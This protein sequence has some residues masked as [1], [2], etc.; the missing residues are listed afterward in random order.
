[1]FNAKIRAR[2]ALAGIFLLSTLSC[3]SGKPDVRKADFVWPDLSKP[4]PR[5]GGGEQDAALIVAIGDYAEHND[6]PGAEMNGQEW[7][8]FF[9]ETLG[10]P[11]NRVDVL[12]N[13]AARSDA[14][15]RKLQALAR[16]VSSGGRMWFVF[17]GH[18][19]RAESRTDDGR[20]DGLLVGWEAGVTVNALEKGSLRHSKVQRIL[21]GGPGTPVMVLDTCYSGKAGANETLIEGRAAGEVPEP[22]AESGMVFAAASGSQYAGQLPGARRPAF[23]YLLLG[24]LRGWGDANKDGRVSAA[25]AVGFTKM[26]LMK[27]LAGERDQ[28]P[29]LR[30][31][32][33]SWV[34]Q[35]AEDG[36]APDLEGISSAHNARHNAFGF[37]G[38]TVMVPKPLVTKVRR[39]MDLD[40][41][42]EEALDEAETN[43][44]RETTSPEEKAEPWCRLAAMNS[45]KN[46]YRAQAEKACA[47][48]REYGK[49][50]REREVELEGDYATVRRFLLLKQRDKREKLAMVDAFL[51][52]Y[53]DMPSGYHQI[54]DVREVRRKVMRGKI[55]L[56]RDRSGDRAGGDDN[57]VG[58][59][60]RECD[61][62]T[63]TSCLNLGDMYAKGKATSAFSWDEDEDEGDG[64]SVGKDLGEAARLYRKACDG[65]IAL[66]CAHL[67]FMYSRGDGVGKDPS[68]VARLFRKAC[69]AGNG[70]ACTNL[71]VMYS[72]GEGVSKDNK[73]AARLFRKACD[74]EVGL[75]CGNL[76]E[77][78][79]LGQGQASDIG[80]AYSLYRSGC[81]MGSGW[82]CLAAAA[83]A[84]SVRQDLGAA[85]QHLG[86]ACK[87]KEEG[88]CA[89]SKKSPTSWDVQR[90]ACDRNVGGACTR[91][92]EG[93]RDGAA[94]LGRSSEQAE[95][96]REKACN[97]SN[98]RV[99]R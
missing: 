40:M 68:E 36:P 49:T 25:E 47:D 59:Y 8:E 60:R 87:L 41:D 64:M 96:Y 61:A 7:Y 34:V 74:A 3:A 50:L 75:G 24:A 12:I 57:K 11:P 98:D 1:M 66:A 77:T 10:V 29:E 30:G 13:K 81:D 89:L 28:T 31:E 90:L 46:V 80:K 76:G 48:W 99:C 16:E 58:R 54:K 69:D 2:R 17:I 19:D 72:N 51:D 93:Y 71:G 21:A 23:S 52:A 43:Q 44:A 32:L 53:I 22:N 62:G 15:E 95:A 82:S 65:G 97:A 78:V 94:G 14:I 63:A 9:T 37:G 67:A 55:V 83:L 92:Y 70:K 6:L 26:A 88:A 86:A 73:E 45:E 56:L 33:A 18:G 84:A 42:V 91:L 38:D 27:T 4:A 79:E 5:V 39:G 85:T 20:P 35:V